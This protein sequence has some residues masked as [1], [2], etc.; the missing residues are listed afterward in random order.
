M[1]IVKN[2]KLFNDSGI[3]DFS[4]E[5]YRVIIDEFNKNE[6]EKEVNGN[7]IPAESVILNA[8][9][10]INEILTEFSKI[11]DEY[12]INEQNKKFDNMKESLTST[13]EVEENMLDVTT[14]LI[15]NSLTYIENLLE[16]EL[17][18]IPKNNIVFQKS[19]D[20]VPFVKE[21]KEEKIIEIDNPLIMEVEEVKVVEVKKQKAKPGRKSKV[22]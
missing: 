22:K 6:R 21:E 12:A 20:D 9:K 17:I 10:L 5:E 19:F 8:N 11:E 18:T 3:L 7:V 1:S 16:V 2:K 4:K 15:D 13:N 14:K